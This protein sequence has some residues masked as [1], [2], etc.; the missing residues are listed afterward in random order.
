MRFV[1]V[2]IMFPLY[3][4]LNFQFLCFTQ[5]AF[6]QQEKTYSL[7]VVP[8]QAAVKLAKKWV[9]VANYLT[10]IAGVKVVFKTAPDIPTFEKRLADKSYDI[11]YMNPYHYVNF[12]QKSGYEALA[13]AKDKKIKGILVVRKDSPY[14]KIEDLKGKTLAFPSPFAFAASMLSRAALTRLKVDFKP[15]YVSSHDSVYENVARKILPA[16]GGVIRTF[17]TSNPESTGKLKVL[18]TS[19]GY[20]PHAIATLPS[21]SDAHRELILK[22]LL[23]MEKDP[24]GLEALKALNLKGLEKG[25]DSDWDDVRELVKTLSPGK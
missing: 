8:Q 4:F 21:V 20:T 6:A 5:M 14:Q 22:A 15:K 23:S 25:V 13:R 3:V 17:K 16:G 19:K 9:P 24:K 10:A 18:W 11:A 2:K 1:F 12:H 7:G